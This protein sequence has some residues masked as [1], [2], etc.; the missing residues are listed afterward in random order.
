MTK[1][2][3]QCGLVKPL[4]QY[5]NY[6]GGRKGTY[7]TCRSCERINSRVKYLESKED[8][9][10][11]EET[12]LQ[13]VYELWDEQRKLGLRPPRTE[14]KG[15]KSMTD[16]VSEMLNTYK[17]RTKD[18]VMPSDVEVSTTPPELIKWLTAELIEEPDYYLDTIYDK[19]KETYRPVLSI[20]SKTMMPVHDDTYAAVLDQILERFYDYEDEHYE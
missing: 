5:R 2:C 13:L 20:D 16:T 17:G 19:L 15:R 9:R 7:T 11:D 18:L 8:L 10:E 3:K 4:A 6:Y 14:S 12:E 1:T